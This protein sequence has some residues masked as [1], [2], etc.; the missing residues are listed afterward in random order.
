M[1]AA[2]YGRRKCW[3]ELT[4]GETQSASRKFKNKNQTGDI[5]GKEE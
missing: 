5:A 2:D 3:D 4:V 1:S